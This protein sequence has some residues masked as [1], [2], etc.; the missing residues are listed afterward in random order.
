MSHE[1]LRLKSVVKQLILMCTTLLLISESATAQTEFKHSREALRLNRAPVNTENI[2]IKL[3]APEIVTLAN[4]LTIMLIEDHRLP[5]LKVSMR[6][7]PGQLADP[8]TMPGLSAFTAEMLEEGTRRRNAT[9]IRAELDKLGAD[10]RAVSTFGVSYTSIDISGLN[11]SADQLLDLLSDVVLHPRFPASDLAKYKRRRTAELERNTGDPQFL[12]NQAFY[13]LVY[14]DVHISRTSPTYASIQALTV[15]DLQR[16]H[17]AHYK[18]SNSAIGIIGDFDSDKIKQTIET[19]FGKWVGSTETKTQVASPVVIDRSR[20]V[21]VDRPKSAQTNI[22]VGGVGVSRLQNDY[23]TYEI[24]NYLLGGGPQS[25]LFVNLRELHGYTYNVFSQLRSDIYPG[26]WEVITEVG[27]EVTADAMDQIVTEL[28]H[29]SA[30]PVSQQELQQ[31]KHAIVTRI[32]MSAER[33]EQ[34]VEN[35]LLLWEIGLPWDY[36]NTYTNRISKVTAEDIQELARRL[37]NPQRL[38]WACVGD[39]KQ[40]EKTVAKYGDLRSGL[41]FENAR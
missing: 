16:F 30:D 6:I 9:Q 33:E 18:P 3:K 36:W 2:P 11:E 28:D 4:G 40:I 15:K 26:V 19:Y 21:V 13:A 32:A 5:T 29:F 20:I 34:V 31:A 24:I 14:D 7:K 37:L 41:I 10:Y 12:A 1:K 23:Y 22:V 38:H 17:D 39:A 8:S 25:R 35:W 27:T